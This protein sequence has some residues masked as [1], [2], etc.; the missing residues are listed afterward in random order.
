M[1][2]TIL[3][4]GDIKSNGASSLISGICSPMKGQEEPQWLQN[5]ALRL[6]CKG[7][8]VLRNPK[9]MHLH[10]TRSQGEL[11]ERVSIGAEFGTKL[12]VNQ[13]KE[14]KPSSGGIAGCCRGDIQH[15][16]METW[17]SKQ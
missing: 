7:A 2:S 15:K 8:E 1:A 10:Q 14:K 4:T 13:S 11:P 9:E 12:K 16:Q 3:A 5:T 17:G 6:G